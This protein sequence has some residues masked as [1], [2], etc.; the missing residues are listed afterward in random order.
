LGLN[1]PDQVKN[2][3]L[4]SPT[5]NRQIAKTYSIFAQK[6]FQTFQFLFFFK[7]KLSCVS[8]DLQGINPIEDCPPQTKSE[9]CPQC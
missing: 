6:N 2:L 5:K 4:L 9:H 3:F 8:N 7:E 1:T